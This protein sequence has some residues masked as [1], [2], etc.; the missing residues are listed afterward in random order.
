VVALKRNLCALGLVVAISLGPMIA[1][2]QQTAPNQN[3]S[4]PAQTPDQQ[5]APTQAPVQPS[6]QGPTQPAPTQVP[7]QPAAPAQQPG[8]AQAPAQPMTPAQQPSQEQTPAQPTAPAQQP[9]PAQAPA[10][11]PAQPAPEQAPMTQQTIEGPAMTVQGAVIGVETFSCGNPANG[12]P[13]NAT[14][15]TGGCAGI[16]EIAPGATWADVV[17][18]QMR[19]IDSIPMSG[20]PVR[21][22]IGANNEIKT[23]DSTV[24]LADLKPGSTVKVDYQQVNNIYVATDVNVTALVR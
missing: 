13:E 3:P 17:R 14:G 23:G 5:T 19:E 21:I 15:S 16:V 4:F 22:L 10:S 2:A 7:A 20:I 24:A 12:T 6:M 1:G 8:P 9:S 11:P 18:S